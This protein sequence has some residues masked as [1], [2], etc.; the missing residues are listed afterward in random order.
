MYIAFIIRNLINL[1]EFRKIK[2]REF[3]FND[4]V[5][6]SFFYAQATLPEKVPV[7]PLAAVSVTAPTPHDPVIINVVDIKKE[8]GLQMVSCCSIPVSVND[9]PV[10]CPLSISPFLIPKFSVPKILN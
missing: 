2:F 8:F 3:T 5:Y 7:S 9:L 10:M 6:Y 1:E 4:L